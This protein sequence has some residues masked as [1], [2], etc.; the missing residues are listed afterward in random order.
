MLSTLK[1]IPHDAQFCLSFGALFNDL[2]YNQSLLWLRR[3]FFLL[4]IH[5]LLKYLYL[6]LLIQAELE[7]IVSDG[8][9]E[10]EEPPRPSPM[11]PQGL[12]NLL[13]NRINLYSEAVKTADS[14][15]KRR[16]DRALKVS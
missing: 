1:L 9:E 2:I 5:F 6:L 7:G 14:M 8:E 15:K 16:Y 12:V 4:Q 11:S 10:E 13:N 3:L